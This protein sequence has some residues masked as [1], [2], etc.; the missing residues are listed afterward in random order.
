[1][2]TTQLEKRIEVSKRRIADYERKVNMYTERFQ[3]NNEFGFSLLSV[4]DS[5]DNWRKREENNN[6]LYGTWKEKY[7]EKYGKD[8]F[9]DEYYKLIGS[10]N[11]YIDNKMNLVRENKNLEYLESELTKVNSDNRSKED[12]QKQLKEAIEHILAEFKVSWFETM[13]EWHH[14]HYAYIQ[15]QKPIVRKWIEK[16]DRITCRYHR[17]FRFNHKILDSRLDEKEKKL[18][19]FI[20]CDMAA[21][22]R[23]LEDY[24]SWVNRELRM[25]WSNA[26]QRLTD[27]C[28]DYDID[29]EKMEMHHPSVSSDGF[30][31]VI[32]DGKPRTIHARM[33]WA[34]EFSDYVQP[35]T[36]YIVTEKRK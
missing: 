28:Q 19:K 15:E 27:K 29:V 17:Q 20:L 2:K 6:A 32:T 22:Y 10:A 23:T 4:D 8:E 1:M 11:S 12:S 13:I 25:K 5:T 7:I 26:V 3:K 35:H 14:R 31:V 21:G 16:K 34:A 30:D 36:R 24:M 18:R 33:I 9:F